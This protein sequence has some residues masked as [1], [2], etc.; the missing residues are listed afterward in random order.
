MIYAIRIADRIKAWL[1]VIIVTHIYEQES[2]RVM[3]LGYGTAYWLYELRV[4]LKD[5][6]FPERCRFHQC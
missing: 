3:V 2:I 1:I 5:I 4:S 6:C